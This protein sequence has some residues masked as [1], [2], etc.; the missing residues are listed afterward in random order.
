MRLAVP[1]KAFGQRF[2]LPILVFAAIAMIVLGKAD[3]LLFDRVRALFADSASPVL[4]IVSEPV[5]AIDGVIEQMRGAVHLY[6]ENARLRQENERLLQWQQ[7][8]QSLAVENTRLR[9]LLKLTPDPTASFVSARVIAN[10][11]GSYWRSVLIDAGSSAGLKRG[12]AAVT[13]EGLVGRVTEVGDRAARVLLLTDV[14]SLIPVALD[15]SRE[16]AIL[17]GD[18]SDRPY[19]QYLPARSTVKEGDRIVTSG[20]GG[21]FPPGLPVGIVSAV[22]NGVAR[23]E[24]YAELSR[25]DFLRIVDYGLS[26]VLPQPVAPRAAKA[27]RN[28]AR[29]VAP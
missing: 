14:N 27:P 2:A 6:G 22:E 8:A 23:V 28:A 16:R 17:A 7:A 19:L 3:A 21:I 11:G 5:A 15:S 13:G 18:N 4:K 9:D 26:G 25:L 24:P 29:D 20:N 1:I 12:Q 10:S